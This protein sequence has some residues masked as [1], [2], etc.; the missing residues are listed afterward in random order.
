[1]LQ[2]SEQTDEESQ[3][4]YRRILQDSPH[5]SVRTAARVSLTTSQL[6]WL[7]EK[8]GPDLKKTLAL[9]AEIGEALSKLETE[10][11]DLVPDE[12]QRKEAVAALRGQLDAIHAGQPSPEISGIDAAGTIFKLSEFK[13]KVVLLDFFADWCPW[14]R[15]MYPAEKQMVERLKNRPFALLGVNTE[16]QAVLTRLV[17]EQGVTWRTWADG[18][19][20]PIAR[21]FQIES[22][23]TLFLI[24][25]EG[26]VRAHYA[27][28]PSE[29]DLNKAIESLLVEAERSPVAAK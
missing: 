15:K 13:G 26:I 14:C 22:F 6:G 21:Q 29:E 1:M 4:F 23:P 28:S 24:D 18:Q 17:A 9:R 16:N 10:L 27:G 8:G 12:Q 2:A 5:K 11:A 7:N 25:A 3:D 19:N 20:G